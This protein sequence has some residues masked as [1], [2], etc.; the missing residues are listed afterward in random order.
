MNRFGVFIL[1]LDGGTDMGGVGRGVSES[2][3]LVVCGVDLCWLSGVDIGV[4]R[5]FYFLREMKIVFFFGL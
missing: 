3:W 2:W 4:I 5:F 1:G